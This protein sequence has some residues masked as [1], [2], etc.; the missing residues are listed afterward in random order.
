MM[1]N[2]PIDSVGLISWGWCLH[3]R[4]EKGTLRESQIIRF[5]L[6]AMLV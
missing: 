6:K 1:V 2:I 4:G 5:I 3:L